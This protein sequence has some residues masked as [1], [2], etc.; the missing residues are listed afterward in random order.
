MYISLDCEESVKDEK[1]F[2][3]DPGFKENGAAHSEGQNPAV[4]V[5]P[6]DFL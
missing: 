4:G 6:L 5:L 3:W 1:K 2:D